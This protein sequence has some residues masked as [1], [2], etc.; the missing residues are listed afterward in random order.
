MQIK[1]DIFKIS[2]LAFFSVFVVWLPF[3][4][5]WKEGIYTLFKN[6]DGPNYI[7]VEKSW[8]NKEYIANTF[9]LQSPLEYY[10]AHLPGYPLVIKI[11]NNV[12]QG[13][14]AML[15]STLFFT[16][17]A[18]ISFYLFLFIFNLS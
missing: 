2:L 17:L 12:F 8:Y 6:Y 14:T 9:S 4:F 11:F 1:K 18:S 5:G 10:P 15:L 13:P 16:V 7:V 3:F